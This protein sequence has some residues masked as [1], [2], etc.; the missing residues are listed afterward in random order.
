VKKLEKLAF[1]RGKSLDWI[2]PPLTNRLGVNGA[3]KELEIAPSTVSKWLKDNNYICRPM[4]IKAATPEETRRID[5][6]AAQVKHEREGEPD[7]V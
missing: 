4:W 2:I 5:A 3:A 6:L 7:V 1:E